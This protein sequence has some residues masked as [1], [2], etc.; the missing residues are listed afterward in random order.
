VG[1]RRFFEGGREYRL[2][3]MRRICLKILGVSP[4]YE[5]AFMMPEFSAK[6]RSIQ[7]K[8][9]FRRRLMEIYI[10]L[11]N[12]LGFIRPEVAKTGLKCYN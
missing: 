7:A 11:Y 8:I 1:S 3:S 2:K 6:S 9:S 12:L 5:A 10:T 4:V